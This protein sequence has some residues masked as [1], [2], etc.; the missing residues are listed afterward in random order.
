MTDSSK[1]RHGFDAPPHDPGM[2]PGFGTETGSSSDL[3]SDP[4][5]AEA[6]MR[7][8]L[9]LGTDTRAEP[10]SPAAGRDA[11]V[12]PRPVA[13]ARKRRFVQDGEIQVAVLN[14]RREHAAGASG[15]PPVNRLAA[16]EAA[17]GTER[18]ARLRAERALHE[19]QELVRDLQTKHGHAALARDEAAEAARAS[20]AEIEM[21]RQALRAAEEERGAAR[22]AREQAEL[23]WREA[24]DAL[25]AER[26]AREE[27]E[28][29]LRVAEAARAAPEAQKKATQAPKPH[30]T[31]RTAAKSPA[32]KRPVAKKAAPKARAQK[33]V[34]WWVRA[35]APAKK[36]TAARKPRR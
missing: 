15:T 2:T 20:A 21:L 9:G 5:R 18:A 6:R 29:A 28:R 35:S 24:G 32:A 30:A 3:S 11:P 26:A 23:A 34:R 7:R 16:A 14:G 31:A 12:P 25:A 10:A 33:P 17:A 13:H 19:A 27:A 22:A 8:A 1:P 36:A 4:D